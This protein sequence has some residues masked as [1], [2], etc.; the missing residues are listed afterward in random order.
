MLIIGTRVLNTAA[1]PSVLLVLFIS[2]L[3]R[4]ES[5]GSGACY[6]NGYLTIL[7]MTQNTTIFPGR[8]LS[9]AGGFQCA[10]MCL[11]LCACWLY[12]SLKQGDKSGIILYL[13]AA[14]FSDLSV[15]HLVLASIRDRI[16][17][18]F[19][20][21]IWQF[22]YFQALDRNRLFSSRGWLIFLA[23]ADSQMLLSHSFLLLI[24]NLRLKVKG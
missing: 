13:P 1:E 8:E 3:N 5:L 23:N 14:G 12:C 18:L 15:K 17:T 16:L 19:S 22:P 21:Q 4:A 9:E 6:R 10:R 2:F 24:H 7:D 20:K 11:C